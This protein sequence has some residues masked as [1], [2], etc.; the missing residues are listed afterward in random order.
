[1]ENDYDGVILRWEEILSSGPAGLA[2]TVCLASFMSGMAG[3]VRRLT[4]RLT[5]TSISLHRE[6]KS[7]WSLYVNGSAASP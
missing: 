4:P 2:L 6:D 1:M 5:T 3:N 7:G